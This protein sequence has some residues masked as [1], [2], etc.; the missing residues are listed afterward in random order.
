MRYARMRFPNRVRA[1]LISVLGLFGLLWQSPMTAATYSLH[2]ASGYG[3]PTGAVQARFDLSQ[4]ATLPPLDAV[5]DATLW[6]VSVYLRGETDRQKVDVPGV[7][8]V[9]PDPDYAR[10]GV[11][12]IQTDANYSLD[13]GS[14][15][16]LVF[17]E[18][19]FLYGAGA[20]TA[21][22]VGKPPQGA[23]PSKPSGAASG[24]ASGG[25][26]K[27]SG[28]PG[29]NT[30]AQWNNS[31]C[32]SGIWIPQVGSHPLYSTNSNIYLLHQS[33]VGYLGLRASEEAD[34]STTLDPNTFKTGI[35]DQVILSD[36]VRG[37]SEGII[38]NWDLLTT[39]FDRK[40]KNTNLGTNLNLITAPVL[41]FPF[42]L[43]GLIGF[44]LNAGFETGRNLKNNIDP[45]GFGFLFR[46]LAGAQVEKIFVK[47]WRFQSIN[48]LSTYQVRLPEEPEVFTRELH[49]VLIPTQGTQARHYVSTIFS[50]MFSKAFGLTLQHEYGALPPGYVLIDNRATVGF[51][52][53]YASH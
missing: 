45:N 1:G 20:A 43:P 31:I 42:H 33:P 24:T 2:A 3:M 53:Q 18:V 35:F 51:T 27:C 25:P 15:P 23:T 10:N 32:L 39:E 26:A 14:N 46:G 22:F 49:G 41:G 11:V 19:S 44:E 4:T 21:S 5:R 7:L 30:G 47:P 28:S 12:Q 50:F 52:M 29:A 37:R 9:D 6:R 36:R 16:S 48:I 8:R 38:L 17:V 34:S 13:P 40:K